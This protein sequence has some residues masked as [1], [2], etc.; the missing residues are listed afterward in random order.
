M[1]LLVL[2]SL[3]NLQCSAGAVIVDPAIHKIIAVA[4]KQDHSSYHCLQ[5]PVMLCIDMVASQQGGGAW[6]SQEH[7]G[8]DT[9]S[10]QTSTGKEQ[11]EGDTSSPQ[12][13]SPTQEP[14][15]KRFKPTPQYL[16]TGY[17]I[18]VTMEPCIM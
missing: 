7:A 12:T 5:H 9:S 10:T 6:T 1:L 8:D 11:R 2:T 3:I 14:N 17:D 15:S 13:S 18:Y 16:C 4:P